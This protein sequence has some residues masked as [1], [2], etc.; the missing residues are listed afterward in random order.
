[1][2]IYAKTVKPSRGAEK[3]VAFRRPEPHPPKTTIPSRRRKVLLPSERNLYQKQLMASNKSVCRL[4]YSEILTLQ[5][6]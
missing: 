4:S 6:H 5:H 3:V 2:C 1:M